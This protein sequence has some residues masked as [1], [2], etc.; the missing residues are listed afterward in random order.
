[1]KTIKIEKKFIYI[2][3][4]ITFLFFLLPYCTMVSIVNSWSF[5]GN[6]VDQKFYIW[7]SYNV[8]G[9]NIFIIK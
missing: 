1:M 9:N 6:F 2:C 5:A 8:L 7:W 4:I 3:T